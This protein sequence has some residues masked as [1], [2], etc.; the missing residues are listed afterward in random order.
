LIFESSTGS[1]IDFSAGTAVNIVVEWSAQ[2]GQSAS[3]I[4]TIPGG[5]LSISSTDPLGKA[6]SSTS[7]YYIP[8]VHN[9]IPLWDGYRWDNTEFSTYTL[10]LGTLTA[11][12]CYD[13]FAYLS[14]GVMALEILDWTSDTVRA[15]AV[16]LEDGRYC[17]SGDKTRLLLGTFYAISTTQTQHDLSLLGI[18]NVYNKSLFN[19]FLSTGVDT[20]TYAAIT[21]RNWNNTTT[22][23][24][25]IVASIV[26]STFYNGECICSAVTGRPGVSLNGAAPKEGVTLAVNAAT[27]I[28]GNYTLA[29]GFNYLQLTERLSSAVSATFTWGKIS[30]DALC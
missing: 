18:G 24:S 16:T 3:A 22:A 11:S 30:S 23:R 19:T 1:A 20:H 10:A 27:N 17:K 26:S 14:A 7:I 29:S 15:T 2:F 9:I 6:A 12:I 28:I 21:W 13:V 8:S 4:D 25:K 5:R